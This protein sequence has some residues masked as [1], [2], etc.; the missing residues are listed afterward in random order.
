MNTKIEEMPVRFGLKCNGH[1]SI[2]FLSDKSYENQN[3]F[4]CKKDQ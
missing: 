3:L 1:F 4:L 2:S